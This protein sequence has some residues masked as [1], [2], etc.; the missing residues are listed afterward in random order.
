MLVALPPVLLGL[1]LSATY[2]LAAMR[3]QVVIGGPTPVEQ[4]PSIDQMAAIMMGVASLTAGALAAMS[5]AIASRRRLPLWAHPWTASAAMG[6]LAALSI[7]ADDVPHLM[8]PL[9][10]TV[11]GLSVL[12]LLVFAIGVAGWLDVVL[13]GLAGLSAAMAISLLLV[14]AC[15]ADHEEPSQAE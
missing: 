7:A 5:L 1:S 15:G 11:V 6:I 14:F 10:D 3:G 9:L 13:G 2:L 8:S 12:L 4:G